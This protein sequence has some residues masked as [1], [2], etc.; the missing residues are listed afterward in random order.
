MTEPLDRRQF[1]GQS[2]A[3]GLPL[4]AADRPADS[5]GS[6]PAPFPGLIV[7]EHEPV[8]LE[9]ADQ[10][11]VADDPKSPGP[12]HFARSVPLAVARDG[13]VLLAHRMNGAPLT[14]AHGFPLRAVV[15]GWYGM[16]AVKWLTRVVVTEHPFEGF[17]QTFDYSYFERE[18]GLP[19]IRP[20]TEMQVKSLIARPGQ[21]E[22]IA[23]GRP[24][25]VAGAAWAGTA[26]VT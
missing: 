19:V 25:R 20:I 21:G 12:I 17:W 13:G 11:V 10:G 23:A 9:G 1:L 15:P 7:R 3:A 5:P 6:P 24:S 18:N 16:A 4:L 26:S 22:V 2:A 8:N 14:R